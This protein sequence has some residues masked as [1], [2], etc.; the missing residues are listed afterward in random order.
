[1]VHAAGPIP[2][3]ESLTRPKNAPM[4]IAF[5]AYVQGQRKEYIIPKVI[6]SSTAG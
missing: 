5:N 2:V 1:M 3:F 6:C 4:D